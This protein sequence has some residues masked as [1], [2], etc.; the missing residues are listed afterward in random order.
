MTIY[1]SALPATRVSSILPDL[2]SSIPG[3][4][5]VIQH[6]PTGSAPPSSIADVHRLYRTE[7]AADEEPWRDRYSF[8]L[9]RGLKLRPRYRPGWTPSWLGTNL[10]PDACE[11]SIEKPVRQYTSSLLRP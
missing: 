6:P 2:A 4:S 11:D 5:Y 1:V 10:D 8:F 9:S 3:P 7:I